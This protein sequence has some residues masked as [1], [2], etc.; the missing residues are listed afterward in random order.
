MCVAI[1][2]LFVSECAH[3]WHKLCI[4]LFCKNT[5]AFSTLTLVSCSVKYKTHTVYRAI[6]TV[7]QR[8]WAPLCTRKF[9][10]CFPRLRLTNKIMKSRFTAT[11]QWRITCTLLVMEYL[12]YRY[13]HVKNLSTSSSLALHKFKNAFKP[14]TREASAGATWSDILA[15]M[16]KG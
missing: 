6:S 7:H 15:D 2:V 12:F 16:N 8:Q 10:S 5:T 4:R 11:V 9:Q 1:Y 13:F 14:R 3:T